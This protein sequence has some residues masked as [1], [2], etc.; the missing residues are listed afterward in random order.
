MA[1][2]TTSP[3]ERSPSRCRGSSLG[4]GTALLASLLLLTGCAERGEGAADG[5]PI[6]DSTYVEVMARLVAVDSTFRDPAGELSISRDSARALIL[7]AHE[8]RPGELLEFAE[9]IGGDAERM[10]AVWEHIR[11]LTDTLEARGWTPDSL[12]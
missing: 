6:D 3:T 12:P 2:H 5:A 7:R 8:V 10:R 4:T 1:R 11:L 9:R